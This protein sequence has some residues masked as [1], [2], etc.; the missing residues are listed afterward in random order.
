M[1]VVDR[2]SP[3]GPRDG[4]LRESDHNGRTNDDKHDDHKHDDDDRRSGD[5]DYYNDLLPIQY[6]DHDDDRRADNHDYDWQRN[7]DDASALR[8]RAAAILRRNRRRLHVYELQPFSP[9]AAAVF[10]DAGSDNHDLRLCKHDDA[11]SSW[12]LPVR[13]YM[14]S[15]NRSADVF[16]PP[17]Y[18]DR[19]PMR[20][21]VP[22]F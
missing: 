1:D 7:H 16:G 11:S 18:S 12:E 6:D 4:R 22:L 15:R 5:V 14:G 10:N 19:Q 21:G 13:L 8:V 9:P 17:I 20:S 2:L 3:L